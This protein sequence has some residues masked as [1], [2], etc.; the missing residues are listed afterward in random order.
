M[1]SFLCLADEFLQRV[2][3]LLLLLL[4][5]KFKPPQEGTHTNS[6]ARPQKVCEFD[7]SSVDL[8]AAAAATKRWKPKITRDRARETESLIDSSHTHTHMR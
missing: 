4:I 2:S 5:T 6:L 1:K 7:L 8:K 3:L